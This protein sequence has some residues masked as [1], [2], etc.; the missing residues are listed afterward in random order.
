MQEVME[1]VIR[2]ENDIKNLEWT[3][4]FSEFIEANNETLQNE[5]CILNI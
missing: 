3:T 1:A 5:L 4:D 2:T